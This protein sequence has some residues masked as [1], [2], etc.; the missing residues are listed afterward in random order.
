MSSQQVENPF[1]FSEAL[2]AQDQMPVLVA[3][4]QLLPSA[5]GFLVLA[6]LV[7]FNVRV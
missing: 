4:F 3:A 1:P 2:I 5:Q 6:V 7:H